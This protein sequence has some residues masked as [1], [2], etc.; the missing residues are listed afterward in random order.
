M[1]VLATDRG[2]GRVQ[3]TSPVRYALIATA[4]G[5]FFA[6]LA[7]VAM[8]TNQEAGAQEW[9]APRTVYLPETGHTLDQVFLDYWREA[10]GAAAFG[11]PITPE[12]T[13]EDGSI[14]QYLQYARFEY[15]PQGNEDG[16]YFA[17]GNLGEELRPFN[18]QRSVA[19][20]TTTGAPEQ[21]GSMTMDAGFLGAW[22]PAEAP[23]SDSPYVRYVEETGH[24]V[25]Y[26]FLSFWD[27]SGGVD[28]LGNPLTEE[29]VIDGVTYQIFK[30]GQVAWENGKDAWLVPVGELLA[31]KYWLD[32]T[33]VAQGSI[34]TYSEEL[35]IPPPTPTPEPQIRQA[36]ADGERW[37]EINLSTQY[38]IAW[39]GDVPVLETYVSTG[40]PG[41]DTPPGTYHI[42]VKKPSEDMEGVIGGEYYNVPEVPDVMYFTDVGHA[43]HGA[44]WHSN[45]GAVMSHGC[46]NVPLG[47]SNVLYNWASIGTRVVIHW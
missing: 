29:Y 13:R 26:A 39:Q 42:L 7:P 20:F 34:P 36:P 2:G 12:I 45:F 31:E 40:K 30:R 1:P 24:T 4:L 14:V 15:Y 41:F 16:F 10:G 6:L 18:L 44:Y 25:R 8:V 23:Q 43:I 21:P 35:F 38:L 28:Y 37:I 11:Y 5:L 22:M 46:V 27:Q 19:S 3:H 32:T 47:T 9:S 33:P 17:L